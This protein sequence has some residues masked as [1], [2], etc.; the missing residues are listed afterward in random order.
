MIALPRGRRGAA[1][2]FCAA[3]AACGDNSASSGPGSP[4]AGEKAALEDAAEMLDERQP[5]PEDAPG[6]LEE[7]GNE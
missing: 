4:G 6:A 1:L 7:A 3:L 5:P 2:L